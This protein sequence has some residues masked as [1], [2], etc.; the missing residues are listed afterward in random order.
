MR[1]RNVSSLTSRVRREGGENHLHFLFELSTRTKIHNPNHPRL[2]LW[3]Y[4]RVTPISG[5][6]KA[7]LCAASPQRGR[8]YAL[9]YSVLLLCSLAAGSAD[10]GFDIFFDFGCEVL[11]PQD[12]LP[13]SMILLRD[14]RTPAYPLSSMSLQTRDQLHARQVSLLC[15]RPFDAEHTQY[16]GSHIA[17]CFHR[18]LLHELKKDDSQNTRQGCEQK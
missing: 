1:S 7:L 12:A 17:A 11:Q 2:L 6:A 5:V 10:F 4:I 18:I 3:A 13:V 8:V 15:A 9:C 14:Q 16:S